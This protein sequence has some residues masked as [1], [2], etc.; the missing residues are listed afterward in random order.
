MIYNYTDNYQFST[1][2]AIDDKPIEVIN[3]TSLLGTIKTDDLRWDQ[4]TKEIV[5]KSNANG[6]L[7]M[8]RKFKKYWPVCNCVTEI[9]GCLRQL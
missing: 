7:G 4:N 3:S 2:L 8:F 5:R 9:L 6:V 1:R